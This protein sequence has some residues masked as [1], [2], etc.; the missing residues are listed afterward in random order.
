MLVAVSLLKTEFQPFS[1]TFFFFFFL[2]GIM[3]CLNVLD[4]ISLCMGSCVSR[5]PQHSGSRDQLQGS[6]NVVSCQPH[7]TDH[8][9][10][11]SGSCLLELLKEGGQSSSA[12]DRAFALNMAKTHSILAT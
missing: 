5:V 10:L 3:F 8:S 6:C 2:N 7:Y 9:C 1:F 11:Y 4:A 12:A